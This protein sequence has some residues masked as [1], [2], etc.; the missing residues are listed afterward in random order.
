VSTRG[1][2]NWRPAVDVGCGPLGAIATLSEVVGETGEV[3]G[4]DSSAEAIS[5]ARALLAHLAVGNVHLMHGDIAS[6]DLDKMS[7]RGRF[8]LA[9]CRLVLLHQ[10]APAAFLE[11]V[12]QLVRPG[13]HVIYQDIIDDPGRPICEPAVPTQTRAWGLILEL[14]SRRS[15]TPDVARD[16]ACLARATGCELVHQRGKFAVLA[17]GEGFEIVQQLLTASRNHLSEA[18]LATAPETDTLIEDLECAKA[19]SYRFW[20]GPLAVE[21]I[22]RRSLAAP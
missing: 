1:V 15:L 21:T 22:V 20:H 13:G 9:Y 4:I 5:K 8:D 2:G 18:G 19:G 16:H 11:R 12:V 10:T 7:L 14:F 6:M 17:A 3:V